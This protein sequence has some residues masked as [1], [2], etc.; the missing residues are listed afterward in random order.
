V[1]RPFA[2]IQKTLRELDNDDLPGPVALQPA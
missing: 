1:P 2:L